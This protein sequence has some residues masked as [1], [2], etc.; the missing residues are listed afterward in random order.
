MILEHKRKPLPAVVHLLGRQ[1]VQLG[2]DRAIALIRS[3]GIE[4]HAVDLEMDRQTRGAQ[5]AAADYISDRTFFGMLGV[6]KVLA[7]DCADYE[8]AEIILDL[9][10]PLPQAHFGSVDFL[11]GGSV[12]DNIF[13]QAAYL[14]NVSRLLNTG[15]R[16]FEQDILS[17]HHHPYCLVSPAWVLD[18]FVVNQYRYCS[19]W[20]SEQA[21]AG[22]A[23]LYALEPSADDFISDFGPPR[24]GLPLGFTVVAEK[25]PQSTS[26]VSPIQDQYRSARDAD[27]YRNHLA[28]MSDAGRPQHFRS[29]TA[30]EL[31]QL[32]IRRSRSYRY[33][34]VISAVTPQRRDEAGLRIMEATYGGNCLASPISRSAICSVYRGNATDVLASLANGFREWRWTVDVRLLGDPAPGVGK[35]LEVYYV[36]GCDPQLRLQRAYLPAEAAGQILELVNSF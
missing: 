30:G 27:V 29:P 11:F 17:Q 5:A 28:E 14:R 1:T 35:D 10:A 33:L 20:V 23:H 26:D 36:V 34:G 12:L 4:P 13:D 24:G 7:I 16:L 21:A 32:G 9:N 25:G 22:F 19:I 15:G 2:A 31:L 6:R 8:G 18:Y 3:H